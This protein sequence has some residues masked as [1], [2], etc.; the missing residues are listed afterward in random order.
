MAVMAVMAAR[1]M[2]E[3]EFRTEVSELAQAREFPALTDAQMDSIVR[4]SRRADTAGLAPSLLLWT[5]T[6]D[7]RA[8]VEKAWKL[9][10]GNAANAYDYGTGQTR[11][12]R[13]HVIKHCLAMANEWQDKGFNSVSVSGSV[14]GQSVPPSVVVVVVEP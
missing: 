2:T 5:P 10:A 11:F 1:A 14:S 8:G 4:S 12:S 9:K 7:L 13:S 3:A 6:F